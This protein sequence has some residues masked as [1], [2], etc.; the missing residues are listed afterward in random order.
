M[1]ETEKKIVRY[2]FPTHGVCPP[3]IHFQLA[4]GVLK[5]VR[6]V[7]GGCP[8]NAQLVGRLLEG[9]SLD[10]VLKYL[11]GISC[12]NNTSC[13]DQL[14]VALTEALRGSL[15]P[16]RSFRLFSDDLTGT[17]IGL[18]G[19]LDGN[20]DLLKTLISSIRGQGVDTIHYLGNTVGQS[21]KSRPFFRLVNQENIRVVLGERDWRCAQGEEGGNFPKLTRKERDSLCLFP[22]V[23]S[24]RLGEKTGMAF[25]GRYL[26]S[27]EDFSDFEPF[28]LEMNM[29]CGLTD[30]M[31]D[32]TVFGALEAMVSQFTAQIVVFS[33]RES[34]GHWHIKDVDFIS[35]GKAREDDRLSWGLLEHGDSGIRFR[36]MRDNL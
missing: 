21:Q 19:E 14:S 23:L 2:V 10:D 25:Y 20:K 8:G 12:R 26:L 17:R 7:G 9:K 27:L 6:F 32:E 33:Q 30:L 16:A 13:P 3:E 18:I 35:L 28:A 31:Q 11:D 5:N 22:Q 1:S 34:W 4:G 29:V 36:V 15:K 24:F